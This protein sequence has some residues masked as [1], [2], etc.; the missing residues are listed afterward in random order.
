MERFTLHIFG[1]GETQI[2]SKDLK[3][4]VKTAELT[5]VQ[6]LVDAVWSKKPEDKVG[7]KE[8]FRNISF[9]DFT[10]ISWA[11]KTKQETF[12]IREEDSAMKVLILDLIAELETKK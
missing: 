11:G 5:K 1:Y 8:D 10:K 7:N 9:F 12:I 2:N 4:K 3:V 6:P